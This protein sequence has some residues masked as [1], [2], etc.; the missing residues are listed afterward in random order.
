MAMGFIIFFVIAFSIIGSIHTFVMKSV[1]SYDGYGSQSNR[2]WR[3]FQRQKTG[4]YL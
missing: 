4:M 3:E 1:E 2:E